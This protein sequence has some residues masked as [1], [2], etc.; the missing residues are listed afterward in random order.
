M[1]KNPPIEN[2]EEELLPSGVHVLEGYR[3]DFNEWTLGDLE[4]Y[5]KA[6]NGIDTGE[7]RR[8]AANT[9]VE[10]PLDGLDPR[11]PDDYRKIKLSTWKSEVLPRLFRAVAKEFPK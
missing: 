5:N 3:F 8:V 6:V 10:W 2:A 1:G 4:D 9:I 11:D 7:F